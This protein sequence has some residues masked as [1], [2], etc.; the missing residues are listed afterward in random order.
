MAPVTTGIN[1]A[2]LQVI[3]VTIGY[4]DHVGSYLARHELITSQWRLMVKQDATGGVYAIF[5]VVD[6][7]LVR[8]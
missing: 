3:S 8:V 4:I 5:P 7:H 1:I 2:Q 6:R